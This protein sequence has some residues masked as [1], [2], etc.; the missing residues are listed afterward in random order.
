MRPP[1]TRQGLGR[2][3]VRPAPA[4][5]IHHVLG[6]AS[7]AIAARMAPFLSRQFIGEL[8]S[9]LTCVPFAPGAPD[10]SGTLTHNLLAVGTWSEE[11]QVGSWRQRGSRGGP[12]ACAAPAHRGR[13]PRPVMSHRASA[14]RPTAPHRLQEHHLTVLGLA[15]S[16]SGDAVAAQPALTRLAAFAA[17]AR[18]TAVQVGRRRALTGL[19][20]P[21]QLE[22][23][24]S[25][26]HC[27]SSVPG[28]KKGGAE[29][30]ERRIIKPTLFH[31]CA[32]QA[33]SLGGGEV[34]LVAA[35]ADGGL[36]RLRLTVPL[37]PGS[38]PDAIQV[39]A[40]SPPFPAWL[41]LLLAED[42]SAG[43]GR[44]CCSARPASALCPA[45][46][47]CKARTLTARRCSPG[48]TRTLGPRQRWT[49]TQVG[50]RAGGDG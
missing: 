40:R 1:R 44:V 26:R 43:P 47:S 36:S 29:R 10:Q 15:V 24:S 3:K 11:A 8:P 6:R 49:S 7:E 35:G 12:G 37:A 39:G 25:R 23:C 18:I 30:E 41:L 31:T 32:W 16:H 4:S 21:L 22:V 50:G 38:Q 13:R 46:R 19:H 20:S 28:K 42:N 48:W 45:L 17:P 33:A 2:L 14:Y 27:V 5:G 9:C 34:A